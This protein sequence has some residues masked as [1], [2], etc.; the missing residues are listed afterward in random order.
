MILCRPTHYVYNDSPFRNCSGKLKCRQ[1]DINKS[2]T[3]RGDKNSNYSAFSNSG[4][5]CS[6]RTTNSQK[7]IVTNV[8]MGRLALYIHE[9]LDKSHRRFR[10]HVTV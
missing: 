2:A 3:V 1:N 10:S 9:H 4:Y 6:A 5:K 7:K 8:R